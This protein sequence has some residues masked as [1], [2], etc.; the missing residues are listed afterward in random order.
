MKKRHKIMKYVIEQGDLEI[1]NLLLDNYNYNIV[2]LI[3]FCIQ[4]GFEKP[5]DILLKRYEAYYVFIW[6]FKLPKD[7][8]RIIRSYA[9]H[10][11]LQIHILHHHILDN[12]DFLSKIINYITKYDRI[13]VTYDSNGGY[14]KQTPKVML[15]YR[16]IYFDRPDIIKKLI[17]SKMNINETIGYF[18]G[19]PFKY[20]QYEGAS[21]KIIDMLVKAGAR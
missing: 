21:D 17:E 20:A 14:F 11:L 7:C 4:Y 3:K 2:K 9:Y 1:M 18:R 10:E 8:H 15:L 6:Q 19:T 12:M 5:F 13:N 16:A